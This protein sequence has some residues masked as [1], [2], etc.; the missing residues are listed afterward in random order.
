[1]PDLMNP[2]LYRRLERAFQKA[3]G[4]KITNEGEAMVYEK[5]RLDPPPPPEPAPAAKA[6][7][8]GEDDVAEAAPPRPARR[9]VRPR[10]QAPDAPR[11][12]YDFI[13]GGEY[14]RVCCPYCHDTRHRLY[15]SHMWGKK[16]KDGVPL[17]FL[18]VCYNEDCLGDA[19]HR[20]D[21]FDKLKY[22]PSLTDAR[23][24]KGRVLSEDELTFDWPG[25][26]TRL[27]QLPADHDAVAYVRNRGFDPGV[28]GRYYG[29]AYCH[30]SVHFLAAKR[31]I[32][33]IYTDGVMKGWQARYV[34]ELP[35]KNKDK[36]DRL[37]PK[38]FTCPRMKRSKVIGNFD[39]AR[40]Y[41][42]VVLVE[43]PFDVAGVGPWG[44]CIL[45]NFV[46]Q[47]QREMVIASARATGQ[48][49]V[50]LL[51]P[52]EYDSESTQV[53]AAEFGRALPG[54]FANVRLPDGTDPGS[55]ARDFTLDYVTAEAARLGVP[56]AFEKLGA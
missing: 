17:T 40:K 20:R 32:F 5:H 54:K 23:I 51:D 45:G 16:D 24:A 14:Y 7:E 21:F 12:Y 4:V 34:G 49:V 22:G 19:D 18:A 53:A 26:V 55:L 31:I 47:Q 28:L 44:G 13:Q 52:E 30:N 10:G 56:V 48:S 11:V 38:S 36:Q 8:D 25:P 35:W 33:P 43:G 6:D 50:L 27:D 1:M 42:T 15:V 9:R 2:T 3:G 41:K 39:N 37:P 46:S 29:F